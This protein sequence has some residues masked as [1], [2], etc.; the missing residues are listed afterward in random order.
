MVVSVTAF[1]RVPMRNVSPFRI[2]KY[3][4]PSH[5]KKKSLVY[6][7]CAHEIVDASYNVAMLVGGLGFGLSRQFS[8]DFKPVGIF[9]IILVV[10]GG[11]IATRTYSNRFYFDES[12]FSIVKND[13]SSIGLNPVVGGEYRWD[14]SKIVNYRFF[15]TKNLPLIFY[16]KETN[17]PSSARVESPFLVDL[18]PGQVHIF[19]VIADSDQ[20]KMNLKK[21]GISELP[22]TSPISLQPDL[23]LFI[24]GLQL[25]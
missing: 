17:T 3:D 6:V 15:P 7:T 24:K 4:Q 18:I 23:E 5:N 9:G 12:A 14:Y 2:S 20:L 11:Y 25:I 1:K 21:S 22:S 10:V 19:P 16:F 8:K 13:G